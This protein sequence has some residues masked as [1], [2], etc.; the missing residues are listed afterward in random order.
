VRLRLVLCGLCI[1]CCAVARPA[2]AQE[3]VQQD[4][5]NSRL[6]LDSILQERQRLQS[7]MERLKSSVRDASRELNNIERQ[8]NAS[9]AALL[10]LE[11]QADLLAEN[12]LAT[13]AELD[14]TQQRL[15]TRTNELNGRLR[16]ISV[17]MC[18][19]L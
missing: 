7:E 15:R 11:H 12:V 9:R 4:L 5:R 17:T 8:R 10:E 14:A 19:Y 13:E 16:S 2:Q 18:R 6:K 1:A 3:R